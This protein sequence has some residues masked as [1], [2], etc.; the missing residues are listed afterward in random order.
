MENVEN[1]LKEIK[2]N[3]KPVRKR[4]RDVATTKDTTA[5]VFEDIEF[6]EGNSSKGD[7]QSS[8][9]KGILK[10]GGARAT[11]NGPQGAG[12]KWN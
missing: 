10:R 12:S 7:G 5:D 8:R 3:Q 2:K 11:P 1:E 4:N 9:T 6:T